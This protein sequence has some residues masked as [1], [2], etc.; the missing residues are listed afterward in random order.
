MELFLHSPLYLAY[1]FMLGV[2]V[3][4]FLNVFIYR[5]HTGRSLRGRSHCLSCQVEL[6]WYELF[7]L[8]SYLT[9]RGR[10]R[11]CK[12]FIP[13]RY[14]LVEFLT[15]GLFL[16]SAWF[17]ESIWWQIGMATYLSILVCVL[18]YDLYHT[19]IPDEF[20]I[21]LT[22]LASIFAILAGVAAHD[23][24]EVIYAIVAGGAAAGPF[25]FLWVISQG[26]WVGLGD[27]KLAFPLG[28][29]VGLGSV[30]SLV[31]LAFW[32]GA[33]GSLL[34]IG[35]QTLL[36]RGQKSLRI[37]GRPLTIKSEIPFAPFLILSF[38]LTYFAG[39]DVLTLLTYV[40]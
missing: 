15:G 21:A 3:G 16:L 10:C 8:I 30:F 2:I 1:M 5:F 20:S 36:A 19:I 33:A 31:V 38:L 23:V 37:I 39:V 27:A 32:L 28:M 4:S 24:A 34:Y 18:V 11:H 7:P 35:G 12:S 40:M 26:R 9:L 17:F 14:F 22:V 13:G 6:T 25:I 29:T